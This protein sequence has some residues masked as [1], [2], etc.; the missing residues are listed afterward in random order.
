MYKI[1]LRIRY[2]AKA[3]Y[4][5]HY[6][7]TNKESQYSFLKT[8]MRETQAFYEINNWRGI[9]DNHTL[10]Q[11]NES[12]LHSNYC[13][14]LFDNSPHLLQ[15]THRYSRHMEADKH[16]NDFYNLAHTN[17]GHMTHTCRKLVTNQFTFLFQ[18]KGEKK[19]KKE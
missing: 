11:Q 1:I 18:R 14:L 5:Y 4:I 17:Y 6:S 13:L 16:S 8:T 10:T 15:E 19:K 12:I 2:D 7:F 9:K 3:S